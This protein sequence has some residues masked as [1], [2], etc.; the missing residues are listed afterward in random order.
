MQS[1]ATSTAGNHLDEDL[2]CGECGYNLRSLPHDA[3][4]PECA[5]PIADSLSRRL[6][7]FQITR[8]SAIRWIRRGLLLWVFSILLWG[9]GITYC[10]MRV[11]WATDLRVAAR[12][13]LYGVIQS[14]IAWVF[15]AIGLVCLCWGLAIHGN[16]I[17]RT[18]ALVCAGAGTLVWISA[19][20]LLYL[21]LTRRIT[22]PALIVAI[23]TPLIEFGRPMALAAACILLTLTLKPRQSMG[24]RATLYLLT[25]LVIGPS[26]LSFLAYIRELL[27]GNTNTSPYTW[28]LW[29]VGHR[30]GAAWYLA[31]L[32]L[33]LIID[34]GLRTPN[35]GRK[36]VNMEY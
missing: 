11:A 8:W 5:T 6:R 31:T 9:L 22:S 4:C 12:W 16:G 26:V 20:I 33:L 27:T 7:A 23:S 1:H 29:S 19:G 21:T 18:V 15:E 30:A 13:S 10:T 14:N 36:T 17:R 3:I 34:R 24:L 2:E 28:M 32:I 25:A 35:E